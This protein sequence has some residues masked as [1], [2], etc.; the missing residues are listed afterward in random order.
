VEEEAN[1]FR[2]GKGFPALGFKQPAPYAKKSSVVEGLAESRL[3][4]A[5]TVKVL[6]QVLRVAWLDLFSAIA[7][8]A[9]R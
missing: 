7:R 2:N 6:I 9:R 1:L 8:L 5:R 4:Y 3:S